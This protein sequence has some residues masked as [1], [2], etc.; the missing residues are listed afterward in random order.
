[1]LPDD[2]DGHATPNLMMRSFLS[3]VP[4][5]RILEAWSWRSELKWTCDSIDLVLGVCCNKSK[6]LLFEP[7]E[8]QHDFAKTIEKAFFFNFGVILAQSLCDKILWQI[9]VFFDVKLDASDHI[10]A[11]PVISFLTENN[12]GNLLSSLNEYKKS[13]EYQFIEDRA[14]DIKHS[15]TAHYVGYKPRVTDKN[16]SSEGIPPLRN[17]KIPKKV[18]I[19]P[20]G[21]P[22][23]N[24]DEHIAMLISANDKLVDLIL[25]INDVLFNEISG[26]DQIKITGN[27][28]F[29]PQ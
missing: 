26:L 6:I 28:L 19:P 29:S 11:E 17:G 15:W 16:V 9:R 2:F 23:F 13:K 27:S 24:I 1:M 12:Y 21:K 20:S 5:N 10:K 25:E 14:N 7:S 8:K 18:F 22:E 3:V 4:H